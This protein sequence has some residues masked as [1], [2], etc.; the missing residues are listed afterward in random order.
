[1]VATWRKVLG[2]LAQSARHHDSTLTAAALSPDNIAETTQRTIDELVSERHMLNV[3]LA[4]LRGMSFEAASLQ[5]LQAKLI[6]DLE[7]AN[8]ISGSALKC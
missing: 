2:D 5:G 1:M 3:P 7:T 8:Q 6:Q 4:L